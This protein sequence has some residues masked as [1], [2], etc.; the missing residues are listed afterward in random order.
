MTV[1]WWHCLGRRC[2]QVLTPVAVL[3]P[4]S[5][6]F[7]SSPC[8]PCLPH[9]LGLLLSFALFPSTSLF[10]CPHFSR[11]PQSGRRQDEGGS[12]RQQAGAGA[13]T[14]ADA[15]KHCHN[16]GV[17]FYRQG[18]QKKAF[19]TA[20]HGSGCQKSPFVLLGMAVK[21]GPRFYHK[22]RAPC[23]QPRN[24]LTGLEHRLAWCVE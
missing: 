5:S 2:F 3:V 14:Q 22:C 20:W 15:L 1:V 24:H 17:L 18:A 21:G 16:K 9:S 4:S 12:D 6:L 7:P 13:V 8:F 19:C 11:C 23:T 10:Q